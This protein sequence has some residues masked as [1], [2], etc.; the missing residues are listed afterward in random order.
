MARLP[1][2]VSNSACVVVGCLDALAA[3]RQL[4]SLLRLPSGKGFDLLS[5]QLNVLH[6]LPSLVST[7]AVV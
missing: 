7:G 3:L 6:S 4:A 5:S 1:S 2:G